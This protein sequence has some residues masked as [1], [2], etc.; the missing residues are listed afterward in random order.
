MDSREKGSVRAGS[1]CHDLTTVMAKT[2]D[3][4]KI[5]AKIP[6]LRQ[7]M[8]KA[9]N[10]RTLMAKR[11]WQLAAAALAVVLVFF[12]ALGAGP[13]AQMNLPK[14]SEEKLIMPQVEAGSGPFMQA[15]MPGK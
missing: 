9:P 7:L 3:L 10:L 14:N 5:M 8:A 4:K 11:H 2:P 1:I 6:D 12:F 15:N 13:I